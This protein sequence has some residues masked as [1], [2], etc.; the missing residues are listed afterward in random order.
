MLEA[1]LHKT[2][3]SALKL[4]PSSKLIM[5]TSQKSQ[6]SPLICAKLATRPMPPSRGISRL[7]LQSYGLKADSTRKLHN[8]KRVRC[9]HT[10]NAFPLT[11]A[12]LAT[13]PMLPPRPAPAAWYH[14]A[15]AQHLEVPTKLPNMQLTRC[16]RKNRCGS[17][18]LRQAGHQANVAVPDQQLRQ[19]QGG[20][21]L[22]QR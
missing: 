9:R 2:A 10:I 12:R 14:K 4:K 3:P 1:H 7:V 17:P 21:V 6:L 16:R 8:T 5:Y 13:S 15:T 22:V 18:H 19:L 20:D 11:C